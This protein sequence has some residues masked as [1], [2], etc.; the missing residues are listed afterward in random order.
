MKKLYDSYKGVVEFAIGHEIKAYRL[1]MDLSKMM[2][3]PGISE[4]CEEL[5]KEELEHKVK[6]EKESAKR[7]ELVSSV[8][9]SK[10]NILHSDVNVFK[11]R[12]E[13][14]MFAIK[15]E[16]ASIKLY[17]DLAAAVKN[18]DARQMFQWLAQ[19]ETEH[20]RRFGKEYHQYLK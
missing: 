7:C 3:L 9:L 17:Q 20:K 8:N 2:L 11:N 6:L 18:E 4:L 14:Y 12:I 5:A 15:K 13:M 1:Y 19:Q 10:Y 16:Q